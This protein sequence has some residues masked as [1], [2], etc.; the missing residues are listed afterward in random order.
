MLHTV[1]EEE[2]LFPRLRGCLTRGGNRLF[3]TALESQHREVDVVYASLKAN[4]KPASAAR[5]PEQIDSYRELVAKLT[6]GYRAHI[7]S[8]DSILMDMARRTLTPSRT[9]AKSRPKCAPAVNEIR[10]R[11]S[12]L[13][14]YLE[15][16]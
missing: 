7:A 15:E 9:V 8:E 5:T 6:A 4:R 2:S 10:Y 3:S 13:I 11:A 14:D 16:T 12:C 1:D